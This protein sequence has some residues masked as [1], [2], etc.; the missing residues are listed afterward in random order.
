MRLVREIKEKPENFTMRALLVDVITP[1][2]N[3]YGNFE[4]IAYR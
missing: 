1:R 3:G 4:E 2:F